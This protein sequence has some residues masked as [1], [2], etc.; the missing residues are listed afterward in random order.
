VEYNGN[1]Y[2]RCVGFLYLRYVCN[3]ESLWDWFGKYILDEEGK[4]FFL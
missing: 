1:T 3:P 4:F 2:V